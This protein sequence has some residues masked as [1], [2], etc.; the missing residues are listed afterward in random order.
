MDGGRQQR[1]HARAA[2]VCQPAGRVGRAAPTAEEP[3]NAAAA[4]GVGQGSEAAAVAG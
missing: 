1:G 4:A 2:R 3:G